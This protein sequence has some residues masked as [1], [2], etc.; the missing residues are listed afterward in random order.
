MFIS[1]QSCGSCIHTAL[2]VRLFRVDHPFQLSSRLHDTSVAPEDSICSRHFHKDKWSSFIIPFYD[3]YSHFGTRKNW[4]LFTQNRILEDMRWKSFTDCFIT[5]NDFFNLH[6]DL[7]S[8]D[9]LSDMEHSQVLQCKISTSILQHWQR[10]FSGYE[11]RSLP[12]RKD[13]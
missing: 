12:Q 8:D 5:V 4:V 6:Q 2:K 7:L 11:T 9:V 10:V 1:R 3:Y 13:Y